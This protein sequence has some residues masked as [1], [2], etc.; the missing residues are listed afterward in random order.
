MNYQIHLINHFWKMMRRRRV[1]ITFGIFS[2]AE[3]Q[4]FFATDHQ[5]EFSF[6]RTG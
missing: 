5:L 6:G 3:F 2:M 1:L 4:G